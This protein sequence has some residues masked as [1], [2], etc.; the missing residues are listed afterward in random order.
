MTEQDRIE[1]HPMHE[2]LIKLAKAEGMPGATVYRGY[3]GFG[4]RHLTHSAK[5]LQLAL[6]LPM[7]FEM[8]APRSTALGFARRVRR[9]APG[10]LMI[11][12]DIERVP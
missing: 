7:V 1:G 5:I 10:S 4:A 9:D 6:D 2:H 8:A 12:I 3:S 11:L